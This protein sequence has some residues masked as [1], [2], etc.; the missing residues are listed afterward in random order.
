MNATDELAPDNAVDAALP[1]TQDNPPQQ[2]VPLPGSESLT[3]EFD[4]SKEMGEQSAVAAI[5]ADPQDLH[6]YQSAR[7]N[8]VSHEDA[9]KVGDNGLGTWGDNLAS[10]TN[11]M[12]ELP[13]GTPG[14]DQGRLVRVSGPSGSVIAKVAGLIPQSDG[15]NVSIHLNPAAAR[16]T[17]HPGGLV[18]VKWEYVG[19]EGDAPQDPKLAPLPQPMA[20]KT[21]LSYLGA[22]VDP[23]AKVSGPANK[24]GSIPWSDGWNVYPWD[25][26]AYKDVGGER[27]IRWPNGIIQKGG[28]ASVDKTTMPDTATFKEINQRGMRTVEGETKA[29]AWDRINAYDRQVGSQQ[30]HIYES[31][32]PTEKPIAKAISEYHFN[33]GTG[34]RLLSSKDPQ[35]RRMLAA[36]YELN[37][38]LDMG[39]YNARYAFLKDFEAGK[40]KDNINS[41]NT[42]LGHLERLKK[43]AEALNNKDFVLYNKAANFILKQE[44][45]PR[46]K[47]FAEDVNAVSGELAKTFKGASGTDP[48]INSWKASINDSDGPRALRGAIDELVDLIG[49]RLQPLR[50]SYVRAMDQQP[51]VD[52]L[53][54]NPRRFLKTL[55]VDADALEGKPAPAGAAPSPTPAASPTPTAIPSGSDISAIKAEAQRRL[56]AK[57]DDKTAQATLQRLKDLGL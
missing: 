42:T 5:T 44:S 31:L 52:L 3:P 55:G 36:A 29:Q 23:D 37:P 32:G 20:S 41:L 26:S 7:M 13:E 43:S 2:T 46:F 14:A 9:L 30:G 8:G 24:D 6:R 1:E 27:I 47:K 17:G 33:P 15:H 56:K 12:V 38:Q 22:G 10:A 25:G 4:A 19:Q 48:E 28:K 51:K 40:T 39:Q 35:G 53:D 11:P 49:G 34:S 21:Q 54:P 57:P 45:D 18:P 50:Q 16:A